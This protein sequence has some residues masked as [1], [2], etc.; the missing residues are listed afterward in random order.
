MSLSQEHSSLGIN[1][2]N[3]ISK[4]EEGT[5]GQD[6]VMKMEIQDRRMEEEVKSRFLSEIKI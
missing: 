1:R 3:T 6:I 5:R 4:V 2:V